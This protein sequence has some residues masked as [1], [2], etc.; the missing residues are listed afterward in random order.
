[1]TP[2]ERVLAQIGHEETSPPPYTLSF[3]SEDVMARLDGH[4]GGPRHRVRNWW[5]GRPLLRSAGLVE[6][7][8]GAKT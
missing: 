7:K 2:R 4:F 3:E 5:A 6:M 8:A 1:M